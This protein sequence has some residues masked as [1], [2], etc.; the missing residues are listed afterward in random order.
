MMCDE[1]HGLIDE[2]GYC[3]SC[4]LEAPDFE[5]RKFI[6]QVAVGA[7]A[8][9]HEESSLRTHGNTELKQGRASRGFV[10]N[11]CREMFEN[12]S[13][14]DVVV[15][16]ESKVQGFE[17]PGSNLYTF[18][19]KSELQYHIRTVHGG[20]LWADKVIRQTNA[21]TFQKGLGEK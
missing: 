15:E 6:R 7:L 8:Q 16:F 19:L 9:G 18:W 21:G 20:K 5:D 11:R 13:R 12:Q 10:C 14:S 4:G 17:Q 3:G 1:C 2:S